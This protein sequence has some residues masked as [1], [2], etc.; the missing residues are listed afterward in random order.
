LARHQVSAITATALSPT[1]TTFFTPGRLLMAAALKPRTLPPNTG[2]A[3]MAAFS[4]PGSCRSAPNTC[5]PVTL[6][7][8]SRRARRL[9]TSAQ[10]DG[11][12]SGTSAGG[13]SLEAASA[14]W[15]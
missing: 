14:T 13:A 7:A 5:L 1:G 10:R 12:F 4:M 8:V 6:S 15:P 3:L 11:S 2:Q 9:P